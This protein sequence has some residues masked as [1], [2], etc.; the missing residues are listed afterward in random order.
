MVAVTLQWCTVGMLVE[1]MV[2][3]V[4]RKEGKPQIRSKRDRKRVLDSIAYSIERD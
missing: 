3:V 1:L 2:T 4:S